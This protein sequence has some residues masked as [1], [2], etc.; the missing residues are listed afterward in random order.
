LFPVLVSIMGV[1]R[2]LANKITWLKQ[3]IAENSHDACAA[4]RGSK[5]NLKS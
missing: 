4:R 3:P 1:N 5:G 2:K